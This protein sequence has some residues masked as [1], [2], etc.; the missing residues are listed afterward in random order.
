MGGSERL[1]KGACISAPDLRL[2]EEE[3][4]QTQ[5]VTKDDALGGV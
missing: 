4:T 1:D 5:Y 2:H 3:Y